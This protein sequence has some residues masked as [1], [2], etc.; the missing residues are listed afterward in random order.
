VN[1]FNNVNIGLWLIAGTKYRY[2]GGNVKL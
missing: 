2:V 1:I